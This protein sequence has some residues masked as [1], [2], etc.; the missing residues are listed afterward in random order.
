MA[1]AAPC[2]LLR[3]HEIIE[4]T[5]DRGLLPLDPSPFVIGDDGLERLYGGPPDG[6]THA[7]LLVRT[8]TE[9]PRVRLYYPDRLIENLERNDP[10]RGLT[11][12]NLRDFATFV[13]ELD[14]LL[15]FAACLAWGRAARPVELELHANVTKVLVVSLFLARTLGQPRLTHEQ[16]VHVRFEVLGRGDYEGETGDVRQRYLDAR[17]LAF[18][19]LERLEPLAPPRRLELLRSFS[20]AP[21]EDKLA[22]CA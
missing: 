2:L 13:E 19:F 4:R 7:M 20:R 8:G 5:Y 18:R 1:D 11:E 21:L 14:H 9:T 16:R 12:E 6:E 10:S 17:R 22:L 3:V 15:L